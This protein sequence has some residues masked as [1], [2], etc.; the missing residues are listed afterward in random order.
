MGWAGREKAQE[1]HS[2]VGRQDGCG[3]SPHPRDPR[4]PRL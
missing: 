4:H 2:E 3:T 1:A